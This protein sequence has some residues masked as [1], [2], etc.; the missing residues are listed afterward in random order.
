MDFHKNK[1]KKPMLR[2]ICID[3]TGIF[4]GVHVKYTEY[5]N[6]HQLHW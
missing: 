4:L 2:H 1:N 3:I 5:T 6:Y